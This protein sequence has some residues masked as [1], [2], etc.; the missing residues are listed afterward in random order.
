MKQVFIAILVSILIFSCKPKAEFKTIDFGD[1][2]MTV[3]RQWNE[4]DFKGTDSNVGGIITP[5]KDSL[6]FDI[7]RYSPDITKKSLPLVFDK[8][9]YAD[10]KFKTEKTSQKNETFNR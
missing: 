1:F 8:K 3:P 9:S 4:L 7:G 10:F 5:E 2:E 6:I